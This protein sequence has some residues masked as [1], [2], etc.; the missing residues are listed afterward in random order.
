[1]SQDGVHL[2]TVLSRDDGSTVGGH[3]VGDFV[4]FTTA[5]VVIG[6]SRDIQ[7]ERRFDPESGFKEL[8]I[9]QL[10]YSN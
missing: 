1:M 6:S 3:V 4:V 5:E 10:D 9:T 2:H 7:F 8:S